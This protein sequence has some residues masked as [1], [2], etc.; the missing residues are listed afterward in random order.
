MTLLNGTWNSSGI[1]GAQ[2]RFQI[3]CLL[4]FALALQLWAQTGKVLYQNDLQKAELDQVP[5]EFLVLDGGFV[6]KQEQANKFVE[7]P[8]APLESFGFLFGPT[9]REGVTASAR[10]YGTNRGRRSPTFA[11]GLNGAAGFRLQVSP[12]KKALEIYRSDMLLTSTPYDWKSGTWTQLR[13]QVRKTDD[14]WIFEGKA[15]PEGQGEPANW[16]I[17]AKE[18]DELPAGRAG[19]FGSPFAGTPIRFDDLLIVQ[20]GGN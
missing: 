10:M 5:D 12:A 11:L 1:L 4:A 18:T 3:L 6:V 19:V 17:S 20:I 9:E 13:V 14:G 16:M 2:T 7:L 8:G 15:W